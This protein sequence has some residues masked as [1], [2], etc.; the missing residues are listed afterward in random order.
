MLLGGEFSERFPQGGA[1]REKGDHPAQLVLCP[2]RE[3]KPSRRCLTCSLT[4]QQGLAYSLLTIDQKNA[5][6]SVLSVAQ[7]SIYQPP[8]RITA[9]HHHTT[10]FAARH[11]RAMSVVP[12]APLKRRRPQRFS[13]GP[14]RLAGV[15][16]VNRHQ[17]WS[18]RYGRASRSRA[19]P[20]CSGVVLAT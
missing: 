17:S 13:R 5:P 10:T 14:S 16:G 15:P 4:E 8:L 20:S 9:P 12:G 2:G 18:L 19:D 6:T 1:Q 7:Q 3:R 11:Q